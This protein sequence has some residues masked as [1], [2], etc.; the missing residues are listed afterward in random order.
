[1]IATLIL[2]REQSSMYKGR[3]PFSLLFQYITISFGF[4]R[5]CPTIFSGCPTSHL[6]TPHFVQKLLLLHKSLPIL[7]SATLSRPS[8]LSRHFRRFS[9]VNT[10]FANIVSER[11]RQADSSQ[12][13]TLR[14]KIAIGQ[15]LLRLRNA[16]M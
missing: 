8:C 13:S 9:N 14:T 15:S 11:G 5:A 7:R 12:T 10:L 16:P 2:F 6:L 4:Q 3:N 1:M